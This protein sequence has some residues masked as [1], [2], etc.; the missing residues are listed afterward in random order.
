MSRGGIDRIE[1]T[2]AA[3]AYSK[4]YVVEYLTNCDSLPNL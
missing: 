3:L 4:A 2:A 1:Y